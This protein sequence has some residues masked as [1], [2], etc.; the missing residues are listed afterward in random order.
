M[1][2][3]VRS[4]SRSSYLYIFYDQDDGTKAFYKKIKVMVRLVRSAPA[5]R[6]VCCRPSALTAVRRC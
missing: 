1:R 2:V 5:V 3:S 6:S 4:A